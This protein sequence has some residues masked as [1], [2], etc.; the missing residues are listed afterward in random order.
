[1][2]LKNKD[3]IILIAIMLITIVPSIIGIFDWGQKNYFMIVFFAGFIPIYT[4]HTTSIGLR[5]R[6]FQFSLIW[7]LIIA[8]NGLLYSQV[9]HL[10]LSMFVSFIF[11]HLLRLIFKAINKEDPIPIFVGPGMGLDYNKTE[12]RM[13]N[14]RDALFTMISFFGGLFLAAFILILTKLK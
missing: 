12:N 14:K 1:M 3:W 8:I 6:N 5:F 4:T 10:W 7:L 9:I 11:Y 2:N 13:E